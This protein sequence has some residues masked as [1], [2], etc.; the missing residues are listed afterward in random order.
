M[1][2]LAIAVNLYRTDETRL[3]FVV[4]VEFFAY[5]TAII[6]A[7]S[8]AQAV[9]QLNNT[10]MR[11]GGAATQDGFPVGATGRL[12]GMALTLLG[13]WHGEIPLFCRILHKIS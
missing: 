8:G 1:G 9:G 2:W 5:H 13:N 11:A 10:A 12:A 3:V 7:A 4:R 6:E